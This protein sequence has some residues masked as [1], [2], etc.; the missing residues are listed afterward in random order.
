M[1]EIKTIGR[2]SAKTTFVKIVLHARKKFGTKP[3]TEINAGRAYREKNMRKICGSPMHN[4]AVQD[5]TCKDRRARLY[6]PPEIVDE[7]TVILYL[8][9]GAYIGS[10]ID[11]YDGF[12]SRFAY[13]IK[14]RVYSF[15]YPLAPEYPYPHALD[16]VVEFYKYLLLDSGHKKIIIAGDSAGGGLALAC[17]KRILSERNDSS[18]TRLGKKSVK[19][20]ISVPEMLLLFSPWVDLTLSMPSLVVNKKRDLLLTFE[21]LQGAAGM[22]C[23]GKDASNSEISPLYCDFAGFPPAYI[24]VADDELLFDEAVALHDNM[25][26]AGVDVYLSV[27][28]GMQHAFVI[29]ANLF[30]ESKLVI[31]NIKDFMALRTPQTKTLLQEGF[32]IQIQE[33]YVVI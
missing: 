18:K 4:V 32:E 22:Y 28:K 16:S 13:E 17:A 19:S 20:S 23:G 6:I 5:I 3:P 24:L 1:K 2:I 29:G 26:S 11:I 31:Q 33:E 27:W 7:E 25:E 9:G 14:M 30:P 10:N 15:D 8:H 21:M 12:A